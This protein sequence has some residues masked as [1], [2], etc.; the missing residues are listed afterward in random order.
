MIARLFPEHRFILYDLTPYKFAD[1][2]AARL[3]QFRLD[4]D[5]AESVM[6]RVDARVGY[7]TDE[8][9]AELGAEFG[10]DVLFISDIRTGSSAWAPGLSDEAKWKKERA[11]EDQAMANQ[12]DQLR[13][14]ETMG[15]R[16]AQFKF[17]LPYGVGGDGKYAEGS[18]YE[19]ADGVAYLQAYAPVFSTETRLEVAGPVAPGGSVPRKQWDRAEYDEAM[20]YHNNIRREFGDYE[21]VVEGGDSVGL[22]T[23]FDNAREVDMWLGYLSY[24]AGAGLA[25]PAGFDW[26][27]PESG[28]PAALA[29]YL[30]AV[31]CRGLPDC[32]S[33]VRAVDR[34]TNCWTPKER[35]L[36][37]A[38]GAPL[39]L[40]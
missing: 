11:F 40:P 24:A 37:K 5:A 29:E 35:N 21:S 1:L 14:A 2:A 13:W 12:A 32:K 23:S 38:T 7:F 16:A 17:R 30:S 39:G 25:D 20:F 3:K 8:T 26:L 36:L 31:I 4:P 6:A 19:Y 9:A 18:A 22:G 28:G 33:G 15:F 10:G 27:D 34:R